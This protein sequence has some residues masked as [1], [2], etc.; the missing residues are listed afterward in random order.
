MSATNLK[1]TIYNLLKNIT[2]LWDDNQEELNEIL[3]LDILEN[4][5]EKE[6][7]T[8]EKIIESLLEDVSIKNKFFIKIKDIY[9]FNTR[10]FRFFF[11]EHKVNNSY[12]RY[13]NRIGLT[14]SNKFIKDTN[15]IV[16]NFPYK[17]CILEGGQSS[18][19]G[20]DTY[21]EY[22]DK[23]NEYEEKS[24]KR[25]EI[26]FNQVLAHDEI[27][28]LLDKKVFLNWKRFTSNGE[29]EVNKLKRDSEG[30][31]RENLIVKGN[32]LLALHSLKNQFVGKIKMIYI[33]PP[34]YFSKTTKSNDTFVYNSN[35][36]LSTWLSFM[37]VRLEVA[38][39][40]L[41][42]DGVIFIS[43][44]DGGQPYLKV[45]MDELFGVEN[46]ISNLPT[47]MN[48]KGNNDEFGFSGTHEYTIVFSKNIKNVK[49]NEFPMEDEEI[50]EQWEEDHIGYFKKGAPMRATGSE[51]KREDRAEMF[52]PILIKDNQVLTIT[53]NEHKKLYDKETNIFD[54]NYLESLIEQ[55]ENNG[56]EVVLP[57]SGK[58]YGRWR[59]GF[60]EKNR[61]RL[62]T[63]V[64]VNRTK[65]GISLY[66]KQRPGLGDLPTKKPKSIFYKPEYSSG[67]G[68]SQ[69]KN[70]FNEKVF[71][72]PKPMD[73]IKD[74]ILLGTNDND[75]ILDYH[76][77]SG[78]SGHGTLKLNKEDG[79]NRK[80]IL[81][82]QMDY[83]ETITSPRVQK[84]MESEN[85]ND[86]FVYF[87]LAPFNQQAQ[88]EIKNCNTLEELILLFD[89]LYK[90]Y[91]LNYNVKVQEFKEKIVNEEEFKNL[92]LI[93]QKKIF[94]DMLDLNQMYINKSEMEDARYSI[95]QEDIDLTND[96]Y[97]EI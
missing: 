56:Y 70:F 6:K 9:V 77:G 87:E 3:L 51:D 24:T 45:L 49:L 36:K 38:R 88:E 73:L 82:E 86:S 32:N 35:F 69:I 30:T 64:I 93:Q 42:E 81:I 25:K 14:D 96:F 15:D 13:K 29:V 31:I 16:L 28:R 90:K 21:Y 74:F 67:N 66:K 33:D 91:F 11:E 54:D 85:I 22:S 55:Y 95:S 63:D 75:I 23:K 4:F 58:E 26:F 1:S 41:T 48:L 92:D 79:G 50:F 60:S 7:E 27:D 65:N 78:T 71:N 37:K 72:N 12:T 83:I 52:Y 8:Y 94:I 97:K 40:L 76:A 59:W 61:D 39:E 62:K 44:D 57:F 20:L 18:E 80:F 46:F 10:D 47:I 5:G 2:I 17:D 34:Y 84:V 53:N 89:S 19:D 68:T 43:I